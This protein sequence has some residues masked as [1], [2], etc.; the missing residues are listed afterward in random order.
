MKIQKPIKFKKEHPIKFTIKGEEL[1][2]FIKLEKSAKKG[3][4][5]EL[6]KTFV[7]KYEEFNEKEKALIFELDN[8]KSVLEQFQETMKQKDLENFSLKRQVK[9]FVSKSVNMVS[10]E[11][12]EYMKSKIEEAEKKNE[13]LQSELQ[14]AQIENNHLKDEIESKNKNQIELDNYK[15]KISQMQKDNQDLRTSIRSSL[16]PNKIAQEENTIDKKLIDDMIANLEKE[17]KTLQEDLNK[18]DSEISE[19]NKNLQE[20]K[21]GIKSKEYEIVELKKQISLLKEDNTKKETEISNLNK[22]KEG[23]NEEIKELKKIQ[24]NSVKAK[25]SVNELQKQLPPS[26]EVILENIFMIFLLNRTPTYEKCIEHILDNF[27][28]YMEYLSKNDFTLN[29]QYA[30][31]LEDFIYQIHNK[32]SSD[33]LFKKIFDRNYLNK[34]EISPDKYTTLSYVK[35]ERLIALQKKVEDYKAKSKESYEKL[36]DKFDEL[37]KSD[38]KLKEHFLMEESSLYNLSMQGV[39]RVNLFKLN[40]KTVKYLSNFIKYVSDYKFTGLELYGTINYDNGMCNYFY[41]A[42]FELFI[43]QKENIS[44]LI[45]SQ[46][47]G[48]D[49]PFAEVLNSILKVFPIKE[50]FITNCDLNT[51]QLNQINFEEFFPKLET[52]DLSGNKIENLEL[53]DN[54]EKL[55][56]KVILR[57]NNLLTFRPEDYKIKFMYLDL[58]GNEFKKERILNFASSFR[59]SELQLLNLS[60]I[61]IEEDSSLFLGECLF[62]MKQLKVLFFNNIKFIGNSLSFL[63]KT[64]YEKRN[65]TLLEVYFNSNEF[66]H[67]NLE[68]FFNRVISVSPE[69]LKV[70]MKNCKITEE[71]I[72]VI[73][74]EIK[75]NKKLKEINL[76]GNGLVPENKAPFKMNNL[77]VKVII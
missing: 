31:I 3:E 62:S 5:A 51:K 75:S 27:S 46:I 21:E 35:Q 9:E 7:K 28:F 71:D 36:K 26:D 66:D 43:N 48:F 61:T 55:P 58:S 56:T 54:K 25:L 67:S 63:S 30:S 76:Q 45:I 33:K 19:L 20:S 4:A 47:K 13:E 10:A 37:I 52:I 68:F 77:D 50:F 38:S 57:K 32:P 70:E 34:G 73:S 65:L 22:D 23:L 72:K 17:N 60:G 11:E 24:E 16:R 15:T 40:S 8:Y 39:L 1:L 12:V 59:G 49:T 2:A 18:K 53:F 14:K 6:T 29:D 64:N 42:L 44:Q 69:L 74:K 41:K